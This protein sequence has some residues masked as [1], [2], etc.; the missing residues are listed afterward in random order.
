MTGQFRH[1]RGAFVRIVLTASLLVLILSP[2]TLADTYPKNPDIDI[3]HY[4]FRLTLS[5]GT[6]EIAGETTV[7]LRFLRQGL[8]EFALDLVK[9]KSD[10][11]KRGMTV[12][13]VTSDL[14]P[15]RFEHENDRVR[16]L[17][18]GA[19]R[20]G[21]IGRF[22]VS[23][24]GLP[25]T[26]LKIG[27]NKYGDRCFFSDNWPNKARHWLP[28]LDHPSD[29]AT[30]EMVVTAPAHYQVVSNG[31]LAEETDL[32][33]G[34]R[35]TRW[36]QSVP[37]ATWLYV[38]GVARFAVDHTQ[39][40][41]HI[42]IQTW[43]YAQDRD[44][45]FYDFAVPTADALAFY[46]RW[47][48]PY[49]YEKMANVQATSVGGGME[50]ASAIFYKETCVTGR[51][52]TRW[53]NVVIHEIAHHWFGNS[54]TEADWDDVWLSEGFATYFTSL[55][56][57]HAYGRDEFIETMR[58]SRD[59]VRSFDAENP[60]YRLIHDNLADMSRVTTSQHYQ[61][62]AWVLHMLRGLLGNDMFQAG[63][64]QYYALYQNKNATTA[65]FRRVMEESS[66][67]ELGWFFKQWLYQ[68]GGLPKLRGGWRFDAANKRLVVN[69]EQVQA[70]GALYR[71]PIE[72]EL[73][74]TK[75]PESRRERI[76]LTGQRQ[77]FEIAVERAP[78]AVVLD[79][80]LWVLMDAEFPG[81]T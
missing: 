50:G 43:V 51:R 14:G 69:L 11:E 57:E 73:R 55:F 32:A 34:L 49:S 10:G 48:G 18:P 39:H 47:I 33:N 42:P 61:K 70:D 78:A 2:P 66:G 35:R 27:P 15:V 29:K 75:D 46:S 56:I 36:K 8:S 58:R 54:V 74:F 23:Y 9:A 81:R 45:G 5:D 30:A 3:L 52:D 79:P 28:T 59:S 40:Y 12:T 22:T 72:V 41:E 19:S 37:I 25:A 20:A 80:D 68:P 16:I 4:I 67:R 17:L 6:D 64:G 71:L 38:L 62:G 65:D 53:R 76:E 21:Q 31:L 44:A 7:D 13:A 60:K 1:T 63:I 26:G 77:A 24:H